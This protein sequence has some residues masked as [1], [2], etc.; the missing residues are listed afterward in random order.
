MSG[1]EKIIEDENF[2]KL[3]DEEDSYNMAEYLNDLGDYVTSSQAI[4]IDKLFKDLNI[5]QDISVYNLEPN[6]NYNYILPTTSRNFPINSVI[7]IRGAHVY[8]WGITP[9]YGCNIIIDNKTILDKR[10]IQFFVDEGMGKFTLTFLGVPQINSNCACSIAIE[11]GGE[12]EILIKKG[13]EDKI[14][15]LINKG[16]FYIN[17]DVSIK[18]F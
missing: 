2:L 9:T 12:F 15:D 8:S 13:L 6:K 1:L 3:L 4:C 14:L 18:E 17:G 7:N 11:H 10:A 16:V 5:F